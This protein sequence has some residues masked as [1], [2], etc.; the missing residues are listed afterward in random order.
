MRSKIEP[1]PSEAILLND[2][3]GYTLDAVLR[4]TTRSFTFLMTYEDNL[5]L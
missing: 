3:E 4:A 2:C 5:V 1:I